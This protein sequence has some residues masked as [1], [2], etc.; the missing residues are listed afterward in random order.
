MCLENWVNLCYYL[1]WLYYI[2]VYHLVLHWQ[3]VFDGYWVSS[4]VSF[5]YKCMLSLPPGFLCFCLKNIFRLNDFA[6]KCNFNS[7]FRIFR[8]VHVNL[9]VHVYTTSCSFYLDDW[10]IARMVKVRF[11]YFLKK[12]THLPALKLKQYSK[13]RSLLCLAM[14]KL[15]QDRFLYSIT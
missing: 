3:L 9:P 1:R 13:A 5:F 11:I 7:S 4:C 10:F 6:G 8:L 2:T 12:L 15:V 14:G